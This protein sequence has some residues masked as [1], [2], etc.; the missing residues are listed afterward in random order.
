MFRGGQ[1][2]TT[3]RS[4]NVKDGIVRFEGKPFGAKLAVASNTITA[5]RK[6]DICDADG[7]MFIKGYH[8][9]F[10]SA[11]VSGT[12][13]L[14]PVGDFYKCHVNGITGLKTTAFVFADVYNTA[15]AAGIAVGAAR[16]T[17]AG[18]IELWLT[19]VTAAT[20]ANGA[21]YINYMALHPA[22]I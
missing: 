2:Y 1:P 12:L 14:V 5:N 13:S 10:G 8:L 4:V 16:C 6:V 20:I 17:T 18:S 3:F 7:T 19:N 11:L 21:L 15:T 22:S 9:L